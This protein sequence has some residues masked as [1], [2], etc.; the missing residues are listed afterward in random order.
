MGREKF[1]D[2]GKVTARDLE[3]QR[4]FQLKKRQLEIKKLQS[5]ANSLTGSSKLHP[6]IIIKEEKDN[7]K[8]KADKKDEVEEKKEAKM[9]AKQKEI[10]EK[11]AKEEQDKIMEHDK[12]L[13]GQMEK[14][15]GAIADILDVSKLENELLDFLL[16]FNRITDSFVGFPAITAT[17]KTSETQAK[18]VCATLKSVKHALKKMQLHNQP[19]DQ[20]DKQRSLICYIYCILQEGF[21][22]F[23]KKDLDGKQIKLFQEV[24]MSIGFTQGAATMFDL[25]VK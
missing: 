1:K 19:A 16:G 4:K 11:R 21:S 22:S 23:G 14:R 7:K 20:W 6:P 17:L 2:K 3:Y 24:L 8:D 15:A 12:Q 5:Y 10:L 13:I 9:S 25:W 18:V